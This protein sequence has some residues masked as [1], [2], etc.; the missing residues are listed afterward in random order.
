VPYKW[1]IKKDFKHFVVFKKVSIN[2]QF[3]VIEVIR[4]F[5]NFILMI[6]IDNE[7]INI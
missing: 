3:V 1:V 7:L 5:L 4:I 6:L 2:L